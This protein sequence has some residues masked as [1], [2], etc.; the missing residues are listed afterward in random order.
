MKKRTCVILLV[1]V[2]LAALAGCNFPLAEA[3]PQ[4]PAQT[5]TQPPPSPLPA[6]TQAV[7]LP[8]LPP[9]LIPLEPTARPA[10]LLTPLPAMAILTISPGQQTE[11]NRIRLAFG[12]DV[13]TAIAQDARRSGSG[14]ILDAPDGNQTPDGYIQFDV[15]DTV[16]Y[17][18]WPTPSILIEIEY[19][20]EGMDAFVLEYDAL[21]GGPYQDGR[22]KP[23]HLVYKTGSGAFKTASFVLKDVYFTNRINGGDFRIADLFDGSETIRKVSLTLLPRPETINVDTCGANPWDDQPDSTAIQNCINK[24]RPGDI[25]T[26]TSGKESPGYQGYLVDKTIFIN[27][28]APRKYMTLTSTDPD[29]HALLKATGVLKGF[30]LRLFARSRIPDPG[31]IDYLT[32][33]HLSLDGNRQERVCFGPDGIANGT[34]DNW[35]S[36]LPE[37]SQAWDPWCN[38]GTLDLPGALDWDDPSQNFAINPDRWSTGHFVD[39]L[40][41][42]NTECGTAFGMG[43]ASV[44]IMNTTIEQ[45]GDHVHASGCSDTDEN[46]GLGDWSDGITFVGPNHLIIQNTV[47]NPSDVGIVFFGGR[48]TI[49][50]DNTIRSLSGNSGAFAGIAIHPWSLGDVSFGQV[51]NNTITSRSD[52]TCGGLHVGINLGP[53]MWGGGCMSDVRTPV[54]G[55][56]SC[57]LDPA[58][59]EGALCP[60]SGPCQ[61]WAS[62][63]AGEVYRL[64]GNTVTGAH[65]NYLV[66]GVDLVGELIEENNTSLSPRW[67]DWQAARDGCHGLTWG[68][69]DKI[70]RDPNL[71]GWLDLRIHCER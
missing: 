51:V 5:V 14:A 38:P 29:N 9:T 21:V 16:F 48:E 60:S 50:R 67:S 11:G 15:D 53:H 58:M 40:Y 39:D 28:V 31:G 63:A 22:F 37:C 54:I 52:E 34:G 71:P 49:I 44:T 47:I 17:D 7:A 19:L 1:V 25:V 3:T 41:I 8:T 33:T 68:P 26:F 12:G 56:P 23:T 24:A 57:S 55:N 20:D 65:V 36:Y 4:S 2:L 32:L 70:A 13:D 46:E 10:P 35:G 18:G 45:A 64:T 61:A 30:V 66:G 43:G 6:E 69:T 27:L 42:S 62:I 59:P